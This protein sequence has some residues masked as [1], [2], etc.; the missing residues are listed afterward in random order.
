MQWAQQPRLTCIARSKIVTARLEIS[1]SP[2]R[3]TIGKTSYQSS[4]ITDLLS[5]MSSSSRYENN[6]KMD[7][8][9]QTNKASIEKKSNKSQW[10]SGQQSKKWSKTKIKICYRCW[11]GTKFLRLRAN[12]PRNR[13]V[14]MIRWLIVEREPT[15][16][17]NSSGWISF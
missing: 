7:R 17:S 6:V 9:A 4:S 10:S 11:E 3:S 5:L 2:L 8:Q 16:C 12:R 1:T 14:H 13:Q 15:L